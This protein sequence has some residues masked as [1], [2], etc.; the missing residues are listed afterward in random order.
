MP[1]A[2][3]D[4]KSLTNAWKKISEQEL[5]NTLKADSGYSQALSRS[6]VHLL[7]EHIETN[8]GNLRGGTQII[9]HAV[10]SHERPG[11]SLDQL[12]LVLVTPTISHPEDAAILRKQGVAGFPKENLAYVD[13]EHIFID[14]GTLG[15]QDEISAFKDIRSA[16]YAS[17]QAVKNGNVYATLPYTSR[18]TNLETHRGE[19]C[20]FGPV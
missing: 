20:V 9:Y 15:I 7:H 6:L 18:S 19:D 17:L 11:K 14:A 8:Y 4:S 16:V 1:A 10:N 13:L 3:E 5:L 12:R 2:G